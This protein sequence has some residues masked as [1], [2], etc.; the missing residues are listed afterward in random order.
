MGKIWHVIYFYIGK[1]LARGIRDPPP[2]FALCFQMISKITSDYLPLNQS[3]LHGHIYAIY[4][5]V[6]ITAAC[7]GHKRI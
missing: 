1:N 3:A 6:N 5:S 2:F 7:R 4:S